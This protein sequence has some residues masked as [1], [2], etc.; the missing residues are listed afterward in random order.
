MLWQISAGARAGEILEETLSE[1]G[2]VFRWMRRHAIQSH[3][4]LVAY[5]EMKL[6][7]N[8]TMRRVL[9]HLNVD[10][11]DN[12]IEFAVEASAANKVKE[13]EKKR[14]RAIHAPVAGLK[15]S[16]VRSGAIGQWQESF[17]DDDV[18]RARDVLARYDV[19]LDEFVLTGRASA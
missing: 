1:F 6:N 5:E 10:V 19:S 8:D 4:L 16:F 17:T 14:G 2:E 9:T 18:K 7:P 15:G 11:H 13:T 12:L 3:V